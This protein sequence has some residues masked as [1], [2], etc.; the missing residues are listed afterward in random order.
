MAAS[1]IANDDTDRS[2]RHG[3]SQGSVDNI[4]THDR[5]VRL[6]DKLQ[7]DTIDFIITHAPERVSEGYR[8]TFEYKMAKNGNQRKWEGGNLPPKTWDEYLHAIFN[9]LDFGTLVFVALKY[10]WTQ[11]G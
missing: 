5:L 1:I 7:Q 11:I 6:A 4:M 8:R 9:N 3:T 2:R 10:I